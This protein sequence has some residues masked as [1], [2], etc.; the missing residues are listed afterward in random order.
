MTW[1]IYGHKNWHKFQPIQHNEQVL[2][3]GI[4]EVKIIR[5][6]MTCWHA[7]SLALMPLFLAHTYIMLS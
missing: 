2:P 5:V 6:D 3:I 7:T 1:A 4:K